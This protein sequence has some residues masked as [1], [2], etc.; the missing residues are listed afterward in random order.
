MLSLGLLCFFAMDREA[1]LQIP[2]QIKSNMFPNW[3]VLKRFLIRYLSILVKAKK[4]LDSPISTKD[5]RYRPERCLPKVRGFY[6]Y[7]V[8]GECGRLRYKF[9]SDTEYRVFIGREYLVDT[10]VVFDNLY[11]RPY[12]KRTDVRRGLFY[13]TQV[14][15]DNDAERRRLIIE[16]AL[17]LCKAPLYIR[18]KYNITTPNAFIMAVNGV[19]DD[20]NETNVFDKYIYAIQDFFRI[21]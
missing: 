7:M 18:K 17:F 1:F 12:I 6:E 20:N 4:L 16:R 10:F 5:I 19:G 21:F 9:S 13:Y 15:I 3:M 14:A 11:K 2:F 8:P